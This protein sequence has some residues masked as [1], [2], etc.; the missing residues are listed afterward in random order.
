MSRRFEVQESDIKHFVMQELQGDIVGM[1]DESKGY[2]TTEEIERLQ[3]EAFNKAVK[4][5][6]E[7]GLQQ[8]LQQGLE[9]SAKLKNIFNF[10]Q[11]PLDELDK[12]VEN[13]L[14]DLALLIAKLLLKK[15]CEVD[16]EHIQK[17]IHDS[18]EYLPVKTRDITVHLN[19]ADVALFDKSDVDIKKQSWKHIVD[20]SVQQGG[21]IIESSTSHIDA[22]V[23]ARVQQLVDQLSVYQDRETE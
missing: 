6:H 20:N 13:E 11:S 23:E 2:Q 21:C 16:A 17:L 19:A 12:Q 7:K 9:D 10:L 18:L 15:E 8:G 3:K 22:T 4:E 1:K 5:G 14:T